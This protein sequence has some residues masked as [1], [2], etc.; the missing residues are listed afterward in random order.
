MYDCLVVYIRAYV[1]I[2]ITPAMAYVYVQ[3]LHIFI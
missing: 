1:N 3:I 2:F